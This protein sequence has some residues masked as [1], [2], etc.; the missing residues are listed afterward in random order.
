[1]TPV[2]ARPLVG[3]QS[4][5][6][7]A[8][9]KGLTDIVLPE[10]IGF[11]D[12]RSLHVRQQVLYCLQQL[13]PHAQNPDPGIEALVKAYDRFR[14]FEP[15]KWDHCPSENYRPSTLQTRIESVID[16]LGERAAPALRNLATSSEFAARK[17]G[18][19]SCPQPESNGS[20]RGWLADLP[21]GQ[22]QHV[23]CGAGI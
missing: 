4:G 18:A 19:L 21:R 3:H 9:Q 2:I 17:L 16:L 20:G 23:E 7:N 5:G 14:D 15:R 13:T 12:S 11:M 10:I 6:H 22:P 1:M 8:L